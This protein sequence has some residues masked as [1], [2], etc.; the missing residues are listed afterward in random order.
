MPTPPL[1]TD[2]YR[3]NWYEADANNCASL[4]TICNFLQVT[5]F[6]HAKSLGFD[7]TRKDGFDRLWVLVRMLIKMDRYPAWEDEVDV[8]TWHRGADGF[9][10]MRDYEIRDASGNRL[11]AVSSHWFLLDPETRRPVIPD[12]NQDALS[13]VRPESVMDEQPER[14]HIR[15][16]LLLI[17]TIT[18]GYTD[19][20]MYNH[21]NNARYIDWILNLFPEE[22]HHS[23]SISSFMIEFLSEVMYQDEIG[24]FASIDPE[25]SLVQG[26]RSGDGK[27]I[28]KARITWKKRSFIS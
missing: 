2:R 19:L 25:G 18:A 3:I 22:M 26:V 11:G 8:S 12:I 28:F 5:A 7:Y 1:W 15:E 14:I 21:V 10:A 17:R 23:Y 27:T 16:D 9:V 20:D 6:R 4:T 13:S 24:L